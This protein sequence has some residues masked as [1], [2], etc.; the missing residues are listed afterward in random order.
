MRKADVLRHYGNAAAAARALGISRAAVHNWPKLVPESSAYKIQVI[1]DG[2]LVVDPADY[3]P[4]A[5]ARNEST[6]AA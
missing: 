5:T 3:P 1:T 6:A 2:A 4:S